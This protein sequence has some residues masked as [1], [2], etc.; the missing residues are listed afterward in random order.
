MLCLSNSIRHDDPVVQP[1]LRTIEEARTLT[2]LI[3]AVWPLARVLAR[4]SVEDVLAE[5]AQRPS[6]WPPCPTCGTGLCSTGFAQRQ[7]ISL[8]GPLRWR[9]RVGRWPHGCDSPQVAPCDESLGVQPYPRTRGECQCLGC[10]RA[11]CVP[12]A[13]AARW[14]GWYGGSVVSPRA[15]WCWVQAAG[16][17]AR[18]S[19][20]TARATVA[21]GDGPP[22]EPL[23]AEEAA[24]PLA[25]GAD[26]VMVPLRPDAGVPRGKIRWRAVTVGVLARR[27]QHR[28]RTGQ[29]VP[30]LQH[31]RLVA[32]LGDSE[33]RKPRLW[34]E[35]LRQG[36][37]CAPPVVWRSEGG[38]GWWRLCAEQ[39]S[40][41]ATGLLALYPAA[42]TLWKSAAAWRDGRTT[43]AHRWFAWAR[44]RFRSG[45]PDG[46]LADLA[47]ARDVAGWPDT[48]RATVTTVYASLERH[49]DPITR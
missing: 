8:V 15:V 45:H 17:Q 36:I 20:Q 23:T 5:R 12:F 40:A 39:L 2:Q 22:P 31:R 44:H 28:T 37:I 24:V 34:L 33:T 19:L 3:L 29:S 42:H 43:P 4:H 25:V 32:V 10:A 21:R 13:T 26:G 6:A 14:L 48:A 11:V 49:R 41:S 30:R 35:A 9:R 38:R 7:L 16:H 27:G 18:A 47:A 1:L 46:V